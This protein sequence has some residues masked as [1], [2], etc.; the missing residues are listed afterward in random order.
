MESE[1]ASAA[2]MEPAPLCRSTCACTCTCTHT[3]AR[4]HACTCSLEP[5]AAGYTL[6]ALAL[7]PQGPGISRVPGSERG[8]SPRRGAVPGAPGA[9]GGVGGLGKG[10][11]G[12]GSAPGSAP[13]APGTGTWFLQLISDNPLAS[14]VEAPAGKAQLAGGL[15]AANARCILSRQVITPSAPV[16]VRLGRGG[17]G[18]GGPGRRSDGKGGRGTNGRGGDPL[19]PNRSRGG[20]WAAV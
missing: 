13:D 12:A 17:G 11:A 16:Q 2:S 10:P 18:G 6:L 15:Y 7:A 19:E 3:H 8:P 4:F 14:V 5:H 9:A 1:H 20:R